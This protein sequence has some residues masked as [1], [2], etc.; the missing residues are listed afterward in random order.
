MEKQN[1]PK[2]LLYRLSGE[3]K[4]GREGFIH[5]NRL[6]WLF[7]LFQNYKRHERLFVKIAIQVWVHIYRLC[8]HL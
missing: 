2:S 7:R 5:E 1:S 8:I 6:Q 3:N 4:Y